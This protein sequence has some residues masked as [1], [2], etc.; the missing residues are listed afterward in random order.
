MSWNP[1]PAVCFSVPLILLLGAGVLPSQET[2]LEKDPVLLTL[3]A[4]VSQFLEG[5][6]IGETQ[7]AYQGLLAGSPLIR[8]AKALKDL[9]EKTQQLKT[10]YGRYC[11]FEQIAAKRVGK[12]LVWF[13]YL[14]KCEDS[15]VVWHFIFYRASVPTETPPEKASWRVITVRFDTELER[16]VWPER[17]STAGVDR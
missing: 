16:L 13:Q 11:G 8:R 5:I 6:S 7:N 17:R 2:P 9:T 1:C 4:R 10:T 15:P 3:D 12:D 14:Y